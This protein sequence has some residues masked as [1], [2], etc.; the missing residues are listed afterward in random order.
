MRS[1]SIIVLINT[2]LGNKIQIFI[3]PKELLTLTN[4]TSTTQIEII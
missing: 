3:F 1:P 4:P 2:M